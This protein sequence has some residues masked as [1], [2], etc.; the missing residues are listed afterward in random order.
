MD[1]LDYVQVGLFCADVCRVLERG[2]DGKKLDELSQSVY[3]AI[4]LLKL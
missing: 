2:T 4:N 3:G 1:E